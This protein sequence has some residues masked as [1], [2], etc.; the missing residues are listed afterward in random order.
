MDRHDHLQKPQAVEGIGTITTECE[1]FLNGTLAD[2]WDQ[3][4]ADVPVWTWTNMLAHGSVAEIAELGRQAPRARRPVRNWRTARAVVAREVLDLVDAEFT[5]R[6]LQ[7][8]ILMPLELEMA[9]RPEV[10]R[11]TP[12]QWLDVV[13]Y[14]IRNQP[15]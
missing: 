10:N 15:T 6:Q 7:L 9:A 4:G 13:D 2:Y 5:L 8:L 1:A 3:K 12:R 14:A 11:W